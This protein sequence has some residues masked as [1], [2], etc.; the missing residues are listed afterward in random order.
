M[1]V[2]TPERS[3]WAKPKTDISLVHMPPMHGRVG[4]VPPA[5]VSM[6]AFLFEV[7]SSSV[8]KAQMSP[9][10]Q[11]SSHGSFGSFIPGLDKNLMG[12]SPTSAVDFDMANLSLGHKSAAIDIVKSSSTTCGFKQVCQLGNKFIGMSD[13]EVSF[14]VESSFTRV[15]TEGSSKDRREFDIVEFEVYGVLEK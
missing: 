7:P 10:A 14:A 12:T 4:D 5:I 3:S 11:P 1:Y 8:K 2:V 13:G 9:L 6:T 15:S